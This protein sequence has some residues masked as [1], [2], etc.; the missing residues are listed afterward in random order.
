MGGIK[1][2]IILPVA[3]FHLAIMPWC[4]GADK[5]VTDSMTFQ[6]YLKQG[7]FVPVGGETVGELRPIVRLDTLDAA[8]ES[9]NEVFH[10]H[11]GRIGAVLLKGFHKPPSGIL[12]NG[13]ILEE[14]FPNDLTVHE[15]GRGYKFHVHL[16]PL[17][18][19][20]HLLIRLRDVLRVRRMNRRQ[21]LLLEETVQG[22]NR[23]G[24]AALPELYPEDNEPGVRIASAH[25]SNKLGFISS[26]LVRMVAG[27]AGT[28]TKGL[29]RAIVAAFPAVNILTIRF[30]LNS[31]FSNT[32]LFSVFN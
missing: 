16:H 15:A 24:I 29:N 7:W 32:K 1:P 14:L 21:P 11:G 26:M 2:F 19:V 20:V 9:F 23:A 25:I 22:G 13:S 5:L 17:P 8:G 31:G 28:V 6:M 4:I 10:K 3:S 18:G 30:I 12:I 27:S